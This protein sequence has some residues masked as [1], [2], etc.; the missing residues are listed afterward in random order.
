M[1]SNKAVEVRSL[2]DQDYTVQIDGGSG[3]GSFSAVE[4]IGDDNL[5]TLWEFGR[6]K[7]WN[8]ITGKGTEL[9]DLKTTGDGSPWQQRRC[10]GMYTIAMLARSGSEDILTMHL[11][12]LSTA[13]PPVKLPTVDVRITLES[14]A[15]HF[16]AVL[17]KWRA[18]TACTQSRSTAA[19]PWRVGVA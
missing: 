13:L 15:A 18:A 14:V 10:G 8:L 9:G 4:F 19:S 17:P 3:L 2:E 12:M 16:P 7:I 1:I 5:L 11:P 6:A